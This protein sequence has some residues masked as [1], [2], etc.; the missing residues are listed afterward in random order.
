M[1]TFTV[2]ES[3]TLDGVMQAP[4]RPD[5]D[6]RGGF[7]HGGWALPYQDEVAMRFAGEGMSKGGAM[8]FG[9]R[10]YDDLLGFWT[11]TPDPNPFTDV[12]V[13]SPK[14]VASRDGGT[15]LGYPNSTVLAGD[16]AETVAA[17]KRELDG[18]VTVLGSGE[19]ARTLFAA[20]LV[21]ELVLLV[22]PLVL[23]TGTTL[24]G[25]AH[26]DLELRRSM[27]TTTGVIIAQYAVR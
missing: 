13:G 8:L 18:A 21:D 15:E 14:Y 5:E 27:T 22:H 9:H 24:F 19:L 12:L 20:G 4:G 3:V 11:S 7:T 26:V 10:T 16:A 6:T 1:A 17:L 23:G 2:F 25:D